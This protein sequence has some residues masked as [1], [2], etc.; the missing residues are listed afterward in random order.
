MARSLDD[1]PGKAASAHEVVGLAWRKSIRSI[2]NG[3]CVEVATLA[4]GRLIVRDSADKC[5]P[6]ATF[7]GNDWVSFVKEI[8]KGFGPL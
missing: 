4:S 6:I 5:G 2:A 3:Q 7:T 8:K 1:T